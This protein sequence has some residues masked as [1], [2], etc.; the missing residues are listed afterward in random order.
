M[1]LL[2]LVEEQL[3]FTSKWTIAWHHN[4]R[5]ASLNTHVQSFEPICNHLIAQSLWKKDSP[6]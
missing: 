3:I 6:H 2:I 4:M 5:D 1:V